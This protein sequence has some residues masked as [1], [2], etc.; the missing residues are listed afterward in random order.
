MLIWRSILLKIQFGISF[1]LSWCS[2]WKF[3]WLIL[4]VTFCYSTYISENLI[5]K[6]DAARNVDLGKKAVEDLSKEGLPRTPRLHQLDITDQSSIDTLK[7]FL[8][9]E[10]GG[11]DVLVNNAAIAFKV[12]CHVPITYM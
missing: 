2:F 7:A 6:Y 3:P 5:I 8:Q 4:N 12:C 11:L 9:K 10:Y 1:W